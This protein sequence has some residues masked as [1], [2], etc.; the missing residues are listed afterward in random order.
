MGSV[1]Q[2][3]VQDAR[4]MRMRGL[5][6]VTLSASQ[7][8]SSDMQ[9]SSNSASRSDVTRLFRQPRTCS[10]RIFVLVCTLLLLACCLLPSLLDTIAK[11]C[12][13][14]YCLNWLTVTGANVVQASPWMIQSFTCFDPAGSNG[15]GFPSVLETGQGCLTNASSVTSSRQGSVLLC[16]PISLHP[17]AGI[18]WSFSIPHLRDAGPSFLQQL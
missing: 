4:C 12:K 10:R 5:R 18:L 3:L 1:A 11:R 16:S 6:H 9:T 15:S 13:I 14:T 17:T 2:L 7:P 8:E